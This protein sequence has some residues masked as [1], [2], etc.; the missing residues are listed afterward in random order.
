VSFQLCFFS[1]P[2]AFC[3]RLL[4]NPLT[5][6]LFT[7]LKRVDGK[8]AENMT[9]IVECPTCGRQF[10][11]DDKL[12]D[13]LLPCPYCQTQIRVSATGIQPE[14]LSVEPVED[15]PSPEAERIIAASTRHK[16]RPIGPVMA[17]DMEG[18]F[19]PASVPQ[20]RATFA[21]VMLGAS[22]MMSLAV[23]AA[24]LLL[25]FNLDSSPQLQDLE[26]EVNVFEVFMGLLGIGEIL[27]HVLT[28]IALC[29][30][31]YRAY[32]NLK[33]WKITGLKYS[34]GWA[35]GYFFIPFLN[36]FR[37]YQIAQEIWKAS[38]TQVSLQ[39]G[40]QW[41]GNKGSNV[42]GAWWASWIIA[43]IIGQIS[44]RMSMAQRSTMADQKA[45]LLADVISELVS[46]L[47]GAMAALMILRIQSRQSQKLE[48][49]LSETE[50]MELSGP[51]L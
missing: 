37:P 5:T 10:R 31:F 29:M 32:K 33:L 41:Q 21:L 27:V 35:V 2:L 4:E 42:I 45:A 19:L 15:R 8:R 3:Y 49:I 38:D 12:T 16:V 18:P 46:I 48:S 34:P 11:V 20:G 17:E 6:S 51:G 24:E 1:N 47:A 25:Y 13:S 30:W 22:V 44:F 26:E 36:L 14:P 40:S 39:A 23:I 7:Q 50:G 9:R 43:N 28:V